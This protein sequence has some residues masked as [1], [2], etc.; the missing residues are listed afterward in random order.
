MFRLFKR[1]QHVDKATS[2]AEGII[3]VILKSRGKQQKTKTD[4]FHVTLLVNIAPMKFMISIQSPVIPHH[5]L[6]NVSKVEKLNTKTLM[7][8]RFNL[9]D[10]QKKQ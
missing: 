10:K 1:I 2:I 8:T 6:K 3:G 9:L 5:L 7:T 4:Y